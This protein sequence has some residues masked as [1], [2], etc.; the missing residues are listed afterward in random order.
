MAWKADR[1][2]L[3]VF[4]LGGVVV[5]G[6]EGV[7]GAGAGVVSPRKPRGVA[8][9]VS[10]LVRGVA[11]GKRVFRAAWAAFDR[12]AGPGVMTCCSL[13]PASAIQAGSS[14]SSAARYSRCV[15]LSSRP[16][17]K[18]RAIISERASV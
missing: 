16:G 18:S 14:A 2:R 7:M 8:S 1:E 10:V 4:V 11:V 5:G 6:E 17:K 9:G 3:V 13:A 15:L 12:V